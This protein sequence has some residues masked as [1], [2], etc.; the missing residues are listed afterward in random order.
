MKPKTLKE[1]LEGIVYGGLTQKQ[2]C[3]RLLRLYETQL[4]NARQQSY[5]L[6][7]KHGLYPRNR[8]TAMALSKLVEAL[9]ELFDERYEFKNEEY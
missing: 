9:E 2:M 5:D 7:L 1:E 8:R 6:G 3:G 4:G